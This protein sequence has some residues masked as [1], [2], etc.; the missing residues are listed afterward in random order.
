MHGGDGRAN[1]S[2]RVRTDA[3][4]QHVVDVGE[5]LAAA[6]AV[7][8]EVLAAAVHDVH[9]GETGPLSRGVQAR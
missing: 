3:A 5:Q 9:L 4:E 2:A 6:E 7:V 1:A 8:D